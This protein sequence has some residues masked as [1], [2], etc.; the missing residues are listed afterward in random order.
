MMQ[1]LVLSLVAAVL[2][3][4]LPIGGAGAQVRAPTCSAPAPVCAARQHVFRVAS[5]DPV[6]SA[7][8]IGPGRLVTN[9]HVVADRTEV[10]VFDADGRPLDGTVI[11]TDYPGDLV[12]LNVAGLKPPPFAAWAAAG[13]TSRL[14]T[15][16]AD[17]NSHRVLVY[18]PGRTL[19]LPAPDKPLARLHHSA[20]SQ[21]GNSGGALVDEHGRLVA[22]ITSGG[23]GFNEAIPAAEL[24][25][26]VARSGPAFEAADRKIGLAYRECTIGL[27]TLNAGR[28]GRVPPDVKVISAICQASGNRQLFDLAAQALGWVRQFDASAALFERALDQDPNAINSRIGL[29]VTLNFARRHALAIPHIQGL[30]TAYPGNMRFLNL[31]VQ[32][33]RLSGDSA[34]TIQALD[35]IDK[36]HPELS[37]R[38]RRFR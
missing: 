33:G 6:G 36:H 29:I 9:R 20:A 27:E 37:P 30:M 17:T 7:V 26:L 5:F 34:F 32:A 18:P 28:R 25:K 23:D 21:P 22:I 12:L 4:S 31:A 16:G 2:V 15:I 10:K 1:R 35:L 13:K 19:A 24:S 8:L 14:F 11:P 38:Y 3:W